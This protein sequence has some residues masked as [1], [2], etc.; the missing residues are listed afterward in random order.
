MYKKISSVILMSVIFTSA[1]SNIA[2]AEFNER[3]YKLNDIIYYD[4]GEDCAPA[5]SSGTANINLEGNDML[6]KSGTSLSLRG[7]QMNRLLE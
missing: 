5:S 6:K 3:F 2:R 7:L 4:A 1:L